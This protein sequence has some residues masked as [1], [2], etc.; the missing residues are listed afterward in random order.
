M[1]RTAKLGVESYANRYIDLVI[2]RLQL[3]SDYACAK[4]LDLTPQAVW[5]IRAGGAMS[6]TTAAKIAEIL[7]LE[8]LKVISEIEHERS[9]D[10]V[11]KR[12]AKGVAAGVLVAIGG[13]SAPSPAPAAEVGTSV[14]YVKSRRRWFFPLV[15][16]LDPGDELLT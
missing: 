3:P 5:K 4:A 6:A 14:Y 16:P 10:E 11:W 13:I 8:P 1:K 2:E 12:I 15:P 7:E 9:A